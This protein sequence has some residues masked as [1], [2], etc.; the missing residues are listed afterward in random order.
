MAITRLNQLPEGSGNLTNDD[1]FVFMDDPSGGGITKKISLSDISNAISSDRLIKDNQ[2]VVLGSDGS[3]TFPSGSI[4]SETNNTIS[5]MPPTAQSGQSL[6]IR[7]T[8]ATWGLDS[9]G[10]IVY[11]SPITISVTLQN[12]AYF[13]TVNYTITGSGV[14]PQ[15]LGRAL[16]GK[17]T[18]VSTSAPDTETIT[19]TIPSNS[20]ITEFTLTLTSVDGTRS[21]D[22]ETEND[23]ALYYDFEENAMPIGQFVTVT[24]NGISNSEHSHVHLVAGDP[25]TVDIYLG[26]DDQYVKIEKNGGDVIVGTDSNNNHWI[27]DT[28]GNLRTPT[29]SIISKGYPGQTQD[30]SS[31]FVSPSGS[32]GGLTSADG[33]QYIQISDDNEI[34][35]GLGWPTN[36]VEWIF[37]RSGILTLPTS[38]S[39][40]FSDGSHLESKY[41]TVV[42]LGS[43]SGTINTNASLGDIF[44]LTLAASG[45]LS[46]P[47]NPTDGQSIRWRIS[48]NAN[49][50]VLNFGNQFKIP[51]SATSPLPISSTS[52]SM[53]ILGATYDSSRNKWDIIAFVPGY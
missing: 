2:E 12:W 39:I 11:G 44:D 33:E 38:G 10:Y 13:G 17:L 15:S 27:F 14:T 31:W 26:D 28:S 20:S 49:N 53:D 6:V 34:Y 46:N 19:W 22:E 43:V 50:L 36:P 47:T 37:N 25:S 48:H 32:L 29:N 52:G 16:T 4:I 30:G 41:P 3:L 45:T 7:P 1:I 18:F 9:S 24:N 42:Q 21:T 8:M 5:L 35:I 51:S 40:T 23:P